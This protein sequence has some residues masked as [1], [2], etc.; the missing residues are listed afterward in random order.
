MSLE[1][2]RLA[3]VIASSHFT[4]KTLQQLVTPGED[5]AALGRVLADPAIGNFE[6]K[7]L[8][9]RP[10]HE[11]RREIESF[12]SNR[13]RDDLLLLYF[14]GHG[15]KSDDGRL[16]LATID[17]ERALPLATTVP[18]NFVND[19]M[20]ASQS[21]CQVLVLDCCHSGAFA[22]GM[23]AK[24]EAS[25]DIRERFEGQGRVVLTASNALQ[26]A[27]EGEKVIGEGSRSVFT[28]HLVCGLETGE[29]DL[30]GDGRIAL[31]EL[32]DY[33]FARVVDETPK[34]RP[35]M[36]AFKVEGDLFLARSPRGPRPAGPE[37]ARLAEQYAQAM[38]ALTTGHWQ[39]ALN[40]FEQ[41]AAA[42][43]TYRDVTE[44]VRPLR[45][46]AARMQR[47]GPSARGW[48]LVVSRFPVAAMLLALIV[49]NALASLFNYTYN[50]RAVILGDE[51]RERI[52]HYTAA[53]VNG[54]AFPVGVGFLAALAWPIGR[55]L[56]RLRAGE[57][58]PPDELRRLRRRCLY[59][60][61]YAACTGVVLW[62]LAGPIYPLSINVLGGMPRQNYVYFS[63]SLFL[64]GLIAAAYPFF[65]VTFLYVRVSYP[66]L[67]QPGSISLEDRG[68]LDRV[69]TFSWQYLLLAGAVPMLTTSLALWIR[70]SDEL[71][72]D[73]SAQ[74]PLLA[75]LGVG[76][77]AGLGLAFWLC[78]TVLRDLEVLKNLAS[79][80]RPGKG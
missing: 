6:V 12:F 40:S 50:Q 7:G 49:P 79:R 32:Y 34:Q 15:I 52:F 28:R 56:R 22:A 9:D 58:V 35:G 18:A 65:G 75:L 53:A 1:G 16:Y 23:V 46:L 37:E 36:W 17:T 62:A 13:K 21:R 80:S 38:D 11:V 63:V 71:S 5:A 70:T 73:S 20:A 76:G 8:I 26:Y 59:F 44:R 64:G 25:V 77:L 2:R 19:T 42:R 60:G 30:D 4:D 10:S 47:F 69:G 66:S 33:V 24:G 45:K 14:S 61:H 39:D 31:A 57:S 74:S 51:T 29:A 48:R 3:L 68:W 55:G 72:A 43:S 54:T 27:F 78:R 41:L 67:V